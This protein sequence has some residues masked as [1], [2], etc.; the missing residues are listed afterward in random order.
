VTNPILVNKTV[1]ELE[2]L[3]QD[4]RV[5]IARIRHRGE[6]IEPA[7][8][9]VIHQDDVVAVLTRQEVH[10]ERGAGV[11]PEVDDKALLDLPIEALDVVVTRRS[12]VGKTLAELAQLESARGVFLRKLTRAGQ[13]IPIAPVP[14]S[15]GE[16][17]CA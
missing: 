9:S 16:T 17:C 2:A 6:I 15:M 7:L 11:G 12:L 10:V 5:F 8:T 1:A 4:V 3:P 14:V 13:E